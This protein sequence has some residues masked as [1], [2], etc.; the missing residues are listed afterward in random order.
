MRCKGL[1]LKFEA[2]KLRNLRWPT[3]GFEGIDLRQHS[4]FQFFK[5][6]NHSVDF[7]RRQV[8]QL[9][10]A[11]VQADRQGEAGGLLIRPHYD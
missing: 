5:S 8:L 10:L 11:L 3:F 4:S 7:V 6:S 1:H 2:G 9:P